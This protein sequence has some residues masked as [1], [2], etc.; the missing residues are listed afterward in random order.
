MSHPLDYQDH[1]I[2]FIDLLGIK[3]EICSS[4]ESANKLLHLLDRFAQSR[5]EFDAR[6]TKIKD[7]HEVNL[8]P[9]V[10]TF[11]DHIVVS[12][13][14]DKLKQ[15]YGLEPHIL[16]FELSSLISRYAIQ[17]LA[18]G[19]LVRGGITI[20]KLYH[21]GDIVFGRGL[22]EAH[23]LESEIAVLPRIIISE[24]VFEY[25]PHLKELADTKGTGI[26][27]DSDNCYCLEYMTGTISLVPPRVSDMQDRTLEWIEEIKSAIAKNLREL[28]QRGNTR[29][30]ENWQW[31]SK[32]FDEALSN[33]KDMHEKHGSHYFSRDT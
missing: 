29:A 4:D 12:Y 21:K 14:L 22:I 9:A 33:L 26:Y 18:C 19:F 24:K 7:G 32:A 27:R 20:D 23:H 5:K 15:E 10:S 2:A 28:T 17:A 30:L 8:R 16:I 3:S 31:F 6:I 25:L 1:L 11:S 13:P